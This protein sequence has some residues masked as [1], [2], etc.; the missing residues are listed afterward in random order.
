MDGGDIDA[1]VTDR[2]FN[3]VYRMGVENP[4]ELRFS[5]NKKYFERFGNEM[6]TALKKEEESNSNN[7]EVLKMKYLTKVQLSSE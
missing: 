5:E 7:Y 1:E 6:E 2:M 3:A 4:V